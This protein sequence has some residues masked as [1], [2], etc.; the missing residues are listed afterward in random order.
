MKITVIGAGYVGTTTSVSFAHYG[1]V[2]TVVEKD[3]HKM[4]KLLK[5]ELPFYEEGLEDELKMQLNRQLLNITN[6]L[7]ASIRSSEIIMITV[8]TPATPEGGANLT[9]V[10]EVAREIGKWI[11]SYK[12][13]VT[14]STVPVGTGDK[15]KLIIQEELAKR[16]ENVPFDVVSNPEFLR[17]GK[18]LQ[19][20]LQPERIVIGSDSTKAQQKMKELYEDVGTFILFTSIRDA[21]MIKYASNAFLAT[22]IS[23]INELARLCELTG[24]SVNQ[25]A[26][27]MGL[28]SRIGKQFLQ[29]G[30][31]YGGSCFPKDLKALMALA[32]EKKTALTILQAVSEVNETQAIW[33]LEKVKESL[34]TLENKHIALLG[35]SF[36][37]GTDDIR[38]ATSLKIIKSLLDQKSSVTAFDPQANHHINSLFPN[39]D[40]VTSPLEAV[41][42]ADA[43]LLLTEWPE[44]VDMDWKKVKRLVHQPL[45]FDG[46]NALDPSQM[47][48]LGFTYTG[49][50]LTSVDDS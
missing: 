47:K 13:I 33:F 12:V 16:N 6:N 32:Q 3:E 20:S 8:G 39:V 40:C 37:P 14:R 15:L 50:G 7:A 34:G 49:V 44:I 19:D 23:F 41:R 24:T 17:E 21:E 31:G 27:G 22:K 26:T 4:K 30:I 35:L 25:V 46:R 10:E 28:D 36:K 1:H 9:Y 48:N 45:L 43:V 29:A 5:S 42:G 2:V 18:A 38:E 11:D